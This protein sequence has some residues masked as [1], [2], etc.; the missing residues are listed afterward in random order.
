MSHL[1]ASCLIALLLAGFTLF[2][3]RQIERRY[4]PVGSFC[5]V[6]GLKL[7][8]WRRKPK[9]LASADRPTVVL[10]HGASGNLLDL[11]MSLEHAFP[12]DVDLLFVDRPGLGY[13]GRDMGR[14]MTPRAQA[15]VIARLL[16]ELEIRN[17]VLVGHSYGAS[18]V[19]ALALV[20]AEKVRG[21]VM[22]APATH[23]WPGGVTWYY[24]LAA[25]PVVGPLF[26]WTLT[27]PVASLVAPASMKHVFAP[28][29]VPADYHDRIGVPLLYRPRSFRANAM[30]I[31]E[32][33]RALA[34]Q[35]SS[36]S[37]ISQPMVVFT[38][39]QDSVVWPSIHS[40]GLVRDCQNAR[41]EVLSGAGHMPQHAHA[42]TIAAAVCELASQDMQPVTQSA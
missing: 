25:L 34:D 13:S 42:A 14:H 35:A 1:I 27:L 29:P 31:A 20:A 6:N 30:D 17:C 40:E 23:P 36:Y 19:A 11:K 33:N 2:R 41:M 26:C 8:Y 4:P 39:T 37:Q 15:R 5:E 24:R 9:A 7:H 38:G 3:S 32:L 10:I 12:A 18:V 21:C 16:D 28:E 22:I